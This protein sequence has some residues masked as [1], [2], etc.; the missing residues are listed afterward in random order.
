MRPTPLPDRAIL[1]RAQW[2]ELGV[3]SDRLAG[4]EFVTVFRGFQTPAAAPA[5]LG[6]MARVLQQHIVPG[7]AISHTTAAA[8]LGIALPWWIDGGIGA[9]S[10]A[11]YRVG[12]ERHVPSTLPVPFRPVDSPVTHGGSRIVPGGSRIVPGGSRV[13]AKG[14]PAGSPA[15][16]TGATAGIDT[17]PVTWRTRLESGIDPAAPGP[18]HGPP[19]HVQ[20]LMTPPVLHCRISEWRR[21][22]VPE[23]VRL[24]LTRR[25]ETYA[26]DGMLLSRPWVVLFE[27]ATMLDH[28]DLVIAI[29]S[30]CARTP[31]LRP[32]R[33][34]E[35][36]AL[37]HSHSRMYGAS[38][39][40]RA[41]RDA[42]PRTDSPG[43]TR[44]RLLLTRAGFA[45][46]VVNLRVRD[47]DSGRHRYLDLAYRDAMVAVEYDGDHHRIAV[48]QRR[49]DQQR[50][51]SLESIGWNIRVVTAEDIKDPRRFLSALRR[52]LLAAGAEVPPE[53]N[54]AG[55]K[56][57]RLGRSLRPPEPGTPK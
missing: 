31:P 1:P 48:G 44:T 8:L 17:L 28:D 12:A 39:L 15:I 51:D 42:R 25:A 21:P 32:P 3:S 13:V 2:R 45:E 34:E 26:H 20:P 24:H 19:P 16:A 23:H 33:L 18:R 40:R 49:E 5:T 47:P 7:A 9:L 29:D 6:A 30:L 22:R 52:T 35:L 57:L 46:P 43:E 55:R 53:S 50:K 14:A 37:T 10:S 56:G 4:P 38:A 27:L 41:L 36:V 11:A 54:W